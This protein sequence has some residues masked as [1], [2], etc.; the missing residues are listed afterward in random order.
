VTGSRAETSGFA[1]DLAY[2]GYA[3]YSVDYRLFEP[4]TGANGW[5]AGLDDVQRAVRW[6]RAHA[7]EQGIDPDR[8][9]ALGHSTGGHL[10]AFLGT[11]AT[12]DNSDPELA[13]YASTVTCVVDLAGETDFT[14]PYPYASDTAIYEQLL[15]G[16]ADTPPSAEAYRDMSPI[17]FVDES[18][19]PFLIIHGA[20]DRSVPVEHSR[21]M[22]AALHEAGIEAIYAEFPRL[23]HSEVFSWS[24]V[25]A[26][27]LAVVDRHLKPGIV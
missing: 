16:T 3:A 21:H 1:A 25:G 2:A 23:A 17:T 7:D 24:L 13:D 14:I 10:A 22:E 5:P 20:E 19:A 15:G 27:I 11:R 18:T 6:L 8:I 4:A 26:L 12:R 9:G